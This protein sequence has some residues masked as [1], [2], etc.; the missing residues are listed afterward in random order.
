M[1]KNHSL[2]VVETGAFAGL[3]PPDGEVID[4]NIQQWSGSSQAVH[5][6]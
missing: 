3:L 1:L 2:H 6:G 5:N 4:N